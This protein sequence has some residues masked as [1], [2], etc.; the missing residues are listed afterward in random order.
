MSTNHPVKE[1]A[2]N[3]TGQKFTLSQV[4][5][6]TEESL[7]YVISVTKKDSTCELLASYWSG[8]YCRASDKF[9]EIV[10]PML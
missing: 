4:F 6:S 3:V 9:K 2:Y 1:F 10:T 8:D 7:G 5:D